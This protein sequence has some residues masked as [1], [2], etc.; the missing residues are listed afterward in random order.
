[1]P[2]ADVFLLLS[3]RSLGSCPSKTT[4]KKS[5]D[6]FSVFRGSKATNSFFVVISKY[7]TKAR[8][9]FQ[10]LSVKGYQE[11]FSPSCGN[12]LPRP[13]VAVVGVVQIGTLQSHIC[14]CV[15]TAD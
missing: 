14:W 9:L 6:P 13:V 10:F 11:T 8:P 12:L 15:G 2:E 1:M 3:P 4:T 5:L 7:I